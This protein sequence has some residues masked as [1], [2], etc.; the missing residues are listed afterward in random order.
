MGITDSKPKIIEFNGLPGT[1]K[2]TISQL[3]EEYLRKENIPVYNSN[4][5][6]SFSEKTYS[7]LLA[8]GYFR[9]II[10]LHNY[11]KHFVNT[12]SL[13][14]TLIPLRYIRMYNHF[15][16]DNKSGDLIIDQGFVQ[17]LISLA[18][19]EFFPKEDDLAN[20]LAS[21]CLQRIPIIFINCDCSVDK[22]IQRLLSR[23]SQGSRLQLLEYDELKRAMMVQYNNLKTLR[24]LMTKVYPDIRCISVD[25]ELSPE[26]NAK[27]IIDKIYSY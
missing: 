20:L 21:S 16:N 27:T 11:S 8:P 26:S 1:G 14:N 18:H 10:E 7:L 3:L 17:G 23:Q 25:A 19:T 12:P 9:R 13:R 15:V 5:R 24:S 4:F 6:H 2:T 22:T